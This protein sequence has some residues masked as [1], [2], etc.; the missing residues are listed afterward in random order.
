MEI[1]IN[2]LKEA[3]PEL[4][5]KQNVDHA[6]AKEVDY[7]L[8]SLYWWKDVYAF[9]RFLATAG[10]D[11]RSRSPV[12]IIGGMSA[13]NP[14]PLDGY[15]HYAVIGDGESVTPALLKALASG[16]QKPEIPGI[17]WPGM[18]IGLFAAP[19]ELRAQAYVETR[20][21]KTTRVEI[22][23]GCR[24]RCPFCELAVIK[25]YRELPFEICRHL[26]LTSPTKNIALFAPDRASH[27]RYLDIEK[28]VARA[29]KRNTGNDVRLDTIQGQ[30][31]ASTLRFGVEALTAKVRK[32]MKNIRTNDALL[33]HFRYIFQEIRTPKGKPLSTCT[34]YMIADLPGERTLAAIEEFSDTMRRIDELC[35]RRFTMF[36]SIASFM[37]APYT[38]MERNDL[39]P[40]TQ[41]NALWE[42]HRY[43]TKNITI[44]SRGAVIGPTARLAQ[45]LT[46]RGDE[47]VRRLVFWLATNSGARKPLNDRRPRAGR[48]LEA[49]IKKTGIDPAFLYRE[50]GRREILP[51]NRIALNPEKRAIAV[52]ANQ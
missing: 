25:P 47:R 15:Y 27:S 26:V 36:L 42:K 43:R 37:P 38:V 8:V 14:F 35:P 49:I 51:S 16:E 31:I 7:L 52:S 40:Y 24:F 48:T 18:K 23:R 33:E 3:F 1:V 4:S 9:V 19:A 30:K 22:A 21:N 13:L 50:I 2:C 5:I 46:I 45:M 44:A 41:F 11:P 6:Q 20:I 39:D 32:R 34:M 12:I 28:C 29:G 17:V 10:I